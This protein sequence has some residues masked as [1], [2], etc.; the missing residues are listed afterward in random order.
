MFGTA[1]HRLQLLLEPAKTSAKQI[2]A[3]IGEFRRNVH[4]RTPS[5]CFVTSDFSNYFQYFTVKSTQKD[6]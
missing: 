5:I 1:A 3:E 6:K 2:S 4:L